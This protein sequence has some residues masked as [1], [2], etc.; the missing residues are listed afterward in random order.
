MKI[1]S[2]KAILPIAW[3]ITVTMVGL[4]AKLNS[5]SSW[6][7]LTGFAVVPPILMMRRWDGPDQTMSE[8]IQQARR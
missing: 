5:L 6:V 2:L 1:I 7:L 3:I 8:S 4:A